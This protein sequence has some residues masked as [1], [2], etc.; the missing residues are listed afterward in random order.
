MIER[1]H[2]IKKIENALEKRSIVWLSGV[3][4]VGKTTLCKMISEADYLNCDLPSVKRKLEDPEIFLQTIT[5]G[6]VLILDEIHQLNDPSNFLKIAADEYPFIKIIAT[7]SSSLGATQK[8]RDSLT[9]RKS[10]LYLSPVLWEECRGSFGI[11]D[12]DRRLLNGGLPEP[13]LSSKKDPEFYLEWINSFYARDIQEL[14]NIRNRTG[15]LSLL[16][17][18]LQ[19]SG[20]IVDYS[21]FSKSCGLS[22]PTVMAHLEALQVAHAVF[23]L[24]PFFGGGKREI[25]KR[26]KCYS[27]DTGFVTFY[28]G[29][30][31]VH[32]KDRGILWEHLV[33]DTL[34]STITGNEFYYWKDKSG[35]EIDF[36]VSRGKNYSD[37]IECKINP[38]KFIFDPFEKFRVLY[39]NG[40]NYCVCP[41]L[42][43]VYARSF[44][45]HKVVFTSSPYSEETQ[46]YISK[47]V[48]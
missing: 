7:G 40:I 11:K 43:E 25:I 6:K 47:L 34:R 14:F 23:I 28:Q 8:F 20:G 5:P 39:P 15:F 37:A 38:D 16:K 41:F 48:K 31:S 9:G 3:R 24:Q 33:L 1:A 13:L 29:W 36:V 21:Q 10:N 27:F 12:F 46:S 26:P 2:W 35:K 19:Q 18:I 32:D 30:D 42:K 4:R 45:I 44:G 22:R 17:L